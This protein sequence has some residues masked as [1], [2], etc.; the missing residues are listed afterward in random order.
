MKYPETQKALFEA[1]I[2][3]EAKVS[4][5]LGPKY[6][7]GLLDMLARRTPVG[8]V[9]SVCLSTPTSTFNKLALKGTLNLT[10]EALALRP[11][12][13]EIVPLKTRSAARRRLASHGTPTKA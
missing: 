10:V 1:I 4:A 9:T 2:D 6:S 3:I 12:F 7:Q 8:V 13:A 11:E 5:L